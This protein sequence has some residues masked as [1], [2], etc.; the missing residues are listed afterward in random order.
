[1]KEKINLILQSEG[2]TNAR[3][4]EI[5]GIQTSSVSHLIAGR[6]KPSYDLIQ[7]ILRRFPRISS[8]WFMLDQGSPYRDDFA[9]PT[10]VE[11]S[12]DSEPNLF[13]APKNENN[14]LPLD[15][16]QNMRFSEGKAENVEN[17]QNNSPIN[18]NVVVPQPTSQLPTQSPPQT[19]QA[20]V[21]ERGNDMK[22]REEIV[23]SAK[24]PRPIRVM[25]FYDDGT[26]ESYSH[27]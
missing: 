13:Y 15:S 16:S 5:L 3:F 6:N 7:K 25:V 9:Y 24:S 19:N 12:S 14:E 22:Q 20:D 18:L 1:M 10:P 27:R 2:L 4:A 11:G 21:Q 8:D 23:H 26:C 17:E